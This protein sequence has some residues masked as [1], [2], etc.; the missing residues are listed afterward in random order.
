MDNIGDINHFLNDLIIQKSI[1]VEYTSTIETIR[2][3]IMFL[4]CLLKVCHRRILMVFIVQMIKLP[5]GS[6]FT[7]ERFGIF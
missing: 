3:T 5:P 7:G 2:S 6:V 4:I 1:I